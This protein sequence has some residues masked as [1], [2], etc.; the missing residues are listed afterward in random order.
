[1]T[2]AAIISAIEKKG[3]QAIP[4][5]H[6]KLE[7][8]IQLDWKAQRQ[9]FV[10]AVC[11]TIPVM[12]ISISLGLELFGS[13]HPSLE[14]G[15]QYSA[16]LLTIPVLFYSGYPFI[17]SACKHL[18]KMSI[19]MDFQIA[20]SS[21]LMFFYSLYSLLFGAKIAYFEAV[22]MFITFI[23]CSQLLER[24][25][26]KKM[27]NISHLL[28][29]DMPL[30]ARLIKKNKRE[31]ISIQ[32]I[33]AGMML[34][35]LPGE[36]VPADGDLLDKQ[37]SLDE[38]S[39]TGEYMPVVKQKNQSIY[40]GSLNLGSVFHYRVKKSS[41]ESTMSKILKLMDNA[42]QQKTQFQERLNF[43]GRHF[44]NII[45]LISVSSFLIW[46]FVLTTGWQQA[47]IVAMSVFII[48]CALN[49]NSLLGLSKV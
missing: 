25:S 42:L 40:S 49:C 39:I 29:W 35:V 20:F 32:Q 36:K 17:Q 2:L 15:L 7:Q 27:S 26:L 34:E 24:K 37:A 11:G 10:V 5:H 43:F 4:Y 18:K 1:M 28:S 19:G 6:S 44:T 47:A 3:Y 22:A 33:Q 8:T 30:F 45:A 31:K 13:V 12:L 23:L 16:M 14:I 38:S 21:L 41:E 46:Y 48:S 9:R